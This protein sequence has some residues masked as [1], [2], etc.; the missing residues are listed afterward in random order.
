MANF[1]NKRIAPKASEKSFQIGGG[2]FVAVERKRELKE[3][4]T[5]LS[6]VAKNVEAGA[7]GALIFAS[8][9][10]GMRE[11]LPQLSGEEKAR[12]IRNVRE[13]EAAVV[14]LERSVKGRV[15]FDRVKPLRKE[16]GFVKVAR[17]S[18]RVKDARP[19]GVRPACR[20]DA[21]LSE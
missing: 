3:H 21:N 6:C 4:S 20:A 15:D 12:I 10:R 8:G 2:F 18:F 1:D 9:A 19:I 11:A 16:S 5:Q 7:G 17:A 14:G 13:P